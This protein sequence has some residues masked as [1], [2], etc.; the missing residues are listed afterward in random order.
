MKKNKIIACILVC[1]L[2]AASVLFFSRSSD[3]HANPSN[4]II[5]IDPGHGG[6]DPGAIGPTG[7][8]EK[9]PNLDIALRVRAKLQGAGYRVIMTRESDVTRS[10]QQR[11]DF[12]NSNGAHLFISI[13]NNAFVTPVPNGT[14][15]YYSL[16]S[17]SGSGYLA[18]FIQSET[19]GQ[20]GTHNRGVKTADF[21]VLRNTRMI[22]ALV[23]GAFMSNPTEEQRLRD[24]N[25]RESMATGIFNGIHR[26]AT[27]QPIVPAAPDVSSGQVADFVTRFYELCLQRPPDPT[28]LSGWVNELASRKKTGSDVAYGFVFSEEFLNRS[29]TNEQFLTIMYRA[30]FNRDPD[31]PGFAGWLDELNR[32]RSR[33]YVLAGFVNSQEFKNLAAAFGINPGTLNPGSTALNPQ[34]GVPATG[35]TPVIT[36]DNVQISDFVT[37]FYNL[38][39]SRNPDPTGLGGWVGELTSRKKSGADVA[40]GFVHSQEFVNKSVSNEEFLNIMYRAFFNRQPDP[41]G[42]NGWL[43]ELNKGRTRQYILAGFV[44]SQEFKNLCASFG[45]NPGRLDPGSPVPRYAAKTVVADATQSTLASPV[46]GAE[47]INDGTAVLKGNEEMIKAFVFRFY[48]TCLNRPPDADGLSGWTKDLLN[49][50]ITGAD[51]AYSFVFSEEFTQKPI[52]DEEYVSILYRAFFNRDPD[53]QGLQGWVEELNSGK[54]R[55]Y[56]LAGFVNSNEFKELCNTYGINPGHLSRR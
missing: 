11:V 34:P 1:A 56:V 28:G 51:L 33:Q 9:E 52:T 49:E 39:L 36:A 24:P 23:E 44:N 13:H 17:P 22:S 37:R 20:A 25:F 38:C 29:V 53:P 27:T 21:F 8:Q 35:T 2:V 6:N 47:T 26:F 46:V 32:G 48:E 5:C 3:L 10:M 45:I 55:I 4:I 14:E 42:F 30:F 40:F 31:G 16:S 50:K 41:A 18:T 15:T 19:V 43:A 54:T 7:L 12:A